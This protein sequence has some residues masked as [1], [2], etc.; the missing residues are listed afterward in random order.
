MNGDVAYAG[1]T[2]GTSI[3]SYIIAEYRLAEIAFSVRSPAT[4]WLGGLGVPDL[5]YVFHQ[6]LEVDVGVQSKLA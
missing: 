3:G 1:P 6:C 2:T 4:P 5:A